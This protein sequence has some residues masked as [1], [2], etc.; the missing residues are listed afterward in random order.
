MKIILL[1]DVRGVGRKFDEKQ[2]SDGYAANFLLPR[3][4]ALMADK[5]GLAKAKQMK[6]QSEAKRS[7]EEKE[8]E[9][10]EA[11]RLEKHKALEK[12]RSEQQKEPS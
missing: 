5:T 12:F 9:E 6:R 10:K 2:V 4:L 1:Q 8:V 11:K 7:A 3:K